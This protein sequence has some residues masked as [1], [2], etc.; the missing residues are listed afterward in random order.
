[1]EFSILKKIFFVIYG[2]YSIIIKK[3]CGIGDFVAFMEKANA[4]SYFNF[5]NLILKVIRIIIQN[6]LTKFLFILANF[7]THT[8]YQH[9]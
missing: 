8:G 6:F 4:V 9:T 2:R 5:N 1:M 3:T 7:G